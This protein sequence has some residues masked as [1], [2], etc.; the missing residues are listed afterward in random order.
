[1]STPRPALFA[2]ECYWRDLVAFTWNIM[3]ME[4][5][6]AIARDA[7]GDAG[8]A[9]AVRLAS[10]PAKRARPRAIVEGWFTFETASARGRGH[11]QL[12][13]GKCRTLLTAMTELKGFEEQRGRRGRSA[14]S[15]APTTDRETWP[16]ARA[17]EA[18]DA[19]RTRAALLPDR[20]RRPGRH[21]LARG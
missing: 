16:E 20:R 3:T 2:E 21:Q 5:Q 19:R 10:V 7:G 18:R 15:T 1:M 4:G 14:S 12:Q 11:V 9:I 6:A 8:A 13:D 17:R